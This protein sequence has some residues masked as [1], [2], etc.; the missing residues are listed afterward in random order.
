MG[1]SIGVSKSNKQPRCTAHRHNVCLSGWSIGAL[2]MDGQVM[3]MCGCFVDVS[4]CQKKHFAAGWIIFVATWH[5]SAEVMI[6]G[7]SLLLPKSPT[8]YF[9]RSLVRLSFQQ[10]M[11]CKVQTLHKCKRISFPASWIKVFFL[12]LPCEGARVYFGTK[13]GQLDSGQTHS[14]DHSEEWEVG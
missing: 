2:F 6:G 7:H 1:L 10:Q 8:F 11:A 5:N 9:V 14:E 4:C 13:Q 12:F 3:G